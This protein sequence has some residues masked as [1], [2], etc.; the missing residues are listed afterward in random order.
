MAPVSVSRPRRGQYARGA[1][2]P[3]RALNRTTRGMAESPFDQLAG[4]LQVKVSGATWSRDKPLVSLRQPRSPPI[5]SRHRDRCAESGRHVIVNRTASTARSRDAGLPSDFGEARRSTR[6]RATAASRG[7]PKRSR[8]AP[9]SAFGTAG[10]MEY[11]TRPMMWSGLS[12]CRHLRVRGRAEMALIMGSVRVAGRGRAR[13][14]RAGVV[15]R[16]LGDVSERCGSV[17]R[18]NDVRELGSQFWDAQE[19]APE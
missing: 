16:W 7:I 11:A 8:I 4:G 9:P 2:R 3:G 13:C 19:G 1:T 18:H 15:G 12:S 17:D 6:M 10:S 5:S 14:R